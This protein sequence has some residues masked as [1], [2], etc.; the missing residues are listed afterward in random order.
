[1]SNTNH[2][3]KYNP[4]HMQKA[5]AKMMRSTKKGIVT[6]WPQ[7]MDDADALYL[8]DKK[9]TWFAW[10]KRDNGQW[11]DADTGVNVEFYNKAL[12]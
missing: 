8:E 6:F 3:M 1:M 2:A 9:N 11:V 10:V 4:E 5:V 7:S 12:A